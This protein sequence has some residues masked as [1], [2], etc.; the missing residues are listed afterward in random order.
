MS[1]FT[2]YPNPTRG[3]INIDLGERLTNLKT[4]LTNSLGQVIITK[5]YLSTDFIRLDIDEPKGIYF[6]QLQTE[7]GAI[8]TKKILK[9]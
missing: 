2:L 9:E 8:I 6:L 5:E 4:T 1:K 7:N 3:S